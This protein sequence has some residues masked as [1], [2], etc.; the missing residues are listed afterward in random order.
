MKRLLAL[1]LAL[2]MTLTA[3]GV[4]SAFSGIIAGAE[5][6]DYFIYHSIPGY[7]AFSE[8]ALKS[9]NET[10]YEFVGFS[11]DGMPETSAIDTLAQFKVLVPD[12]WGGLNMLTVNKRNLLQ[13]DGI[14]WAAK[15]LIGGADIFGDTGLN[16]EDA[17]GFMFYVAVNGI[18]YTGS[19]RVTAM[20]APSKGPYYSVS[21]DNDEQDM[22]DC[23]MGFVYETDT[24]YPG[25]DGY[26]FLDFKTSFKCVDWWSVNDE[27]VHVDGSFEPFPKNKIALFNALQIRLGSVQANDIISIGDFRICEDTRIHTD[28]LDEQ[29]AVF[30]SLDP[31]A[32]TEE[33]Y[34][35]AS[36]AYL[37]A[38]EVYMNPENQK[39]VN[40]AV[41]SLK[42]AIKDLDPLFNKK[43]PDVILSGFEGWSEEEIDLMSVAGLDSVT[44]TEDYAP[45]GKET[46]FM[47]MANATSG[48]PTYGWSWF[49]TATTND[50]ES[51][52]PIRNPF[53]LMEGSKPLSESSGIRFWIKW[54]ETFEQIPGAM[55][56]GVGSSS[57]G[58]YFECEDYYVKVPESEGY[59]GVQWSAFADINGEEDIYD[60]ID[61]LDYINI[62][63]E[64]AVG[65][66]YLSDLHA[67]MW[68]ISEADFEPLSKT[69]NETY[70]YMASLTK[71][72]WYYKSWNRVMD[73]LAA[74][75]KI[76]GKYGATIEEVQEA[77]DNITTNVSKLVLRRDLATEETMLKLEAL[78]KAA[79]SYWR[80]NL[81]PSTYVVMDE[82]NEIAKELIEE[83]CSEESA[84]EAI[85]S[86]NA[87]ISGLLPI[88]GEKTT[89]IYSL[90]SYSNREFN[91]ATMHR[92]EN[93]VYTLEAAANVPY[94]PEGYAKAL[95]ISGTAEL[96]TM[97]ETAK[98]SIH[99]KAANAESGEPIKLGKNYENLLMG[100]LSGTDGLCLWVSVNDMKY[101]PDGKLQVAVSNCTVG[102]LFERYTN[103]IPIPESG[104]GWIY[105]PWEYF[106]IYDD[107]THGEQI[108]LAKIYFYIFKLYGRYTEEFEFYATGLHAYKNVTTT[109][110]ET[111]VIENI[112]DGQVID[113]TET[114]FVPKWSCGTAEYDGKWFS[115]GDSVYDNG[116]HT[117]TVTNGNKSTSVTFTVV[118]DEEIVY[119]IPV[120]SGVENGGEYT[121]ATV[122][123]D[124][125]TATLNGEAIENGTEI[126][127]FGSYT[128]IVTNGDKQVIINFAV[129]EEII[130][131][132]IPGDLDKDGIIT[133]SDALAALRVAAKM[134][135]ETEEI[136][137]IGDADADG[138]ITV[139]DAL[140]ILR[141]AAKM[142]D[143]IRPE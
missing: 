97:T 94:I 2:L 29:L 32:Y 101:F 124:V 108:N 81:I 114:D 140:A 71:D 27:G 24:M 37:Q 30:D 35:V 28:E 88:T 43:D 119:E 118:G 90:E 107:W 31:E 1:T 136:V 123:W 110:W 113:I 79:D 126:T 128:L 7:N 68:D 139:S 93:A 23:P 120:V 89:N 6:L 15:D 11:A 38:Y 58:V 122:T 80:G 105:I 66:Y 121:S 4:A 131:D 134:A 41:E 48:P 63:A 82:A 61:S 46:S 73:S 135:E 56:V 64:E 130:P 17:A 84:Q 117:F 112:T 98:S 45:I 75:E 141:V 85:A 104:H 78:S 142:S 62:F 44:Y 60:Y 33:S 70:A 92:H 99:F 86:M 19:V 132:Y 96:E 95:K 42:Q 143:S 20:Q 36:D 22:L 129:V 115:N 138:K 16:F 125:G 9:I 3:F 74:G 51:V 103:L 69:V 77:I 26:V 100:D 54:D 49:T 109:E 40:N 53:E 18:P 133:V 55:R 91:R 106:E 111:P 52:T 12:S 8:S 65:I 13:E 67:F 47:V 39:Q 83:G 116:E 25:G 21:E 10:R 87:A 127:E 76:I 137:L 72:D 102:P 14:N 57:D 59:I 50:D 5:F 34:Q